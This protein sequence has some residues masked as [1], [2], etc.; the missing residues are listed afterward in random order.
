MN[1]YMHVS[2]DHVENGR[3]VNV[4][5]RNVCDTTNNLGVRRK[6]GATRYKELDHVLPG[7]WVLRKLL[8]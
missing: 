2:W 3:R 6:S 4:Y 8:D 7:V 5:S 1:Y